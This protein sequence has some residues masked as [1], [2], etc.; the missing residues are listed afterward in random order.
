MARLLVKIQ[1]A[2]RAKLLEQYRPELMA[3][4]LEHLLEL[5]VCSLEQFLQVQKMKDS[6]LGTVVQLAKEEHLRKEGQMMVLKRKRPARARIE[7]G[8]MGHSWLG[9]LTTAAEE[10]R[11]IAVQV[12]S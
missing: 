4:C 5:K 8:S 3:Y 1:R 11:K 10:E 9:W 6:Q 12:S 2:L 7:L